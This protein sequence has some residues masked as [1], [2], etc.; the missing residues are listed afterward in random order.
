RCSP[1]TANG[2][3]RI[4]ILD[5]EL[6][7]SD[8]GHGV[9]PGITMGWRCGNIRIG[10]PFVV[11]QLIDEP[12]GLKGSRRLDLRHRCAESRAAVEMP[13]RVGV[14]FARAGGPWVERGG[15]LLA[16]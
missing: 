14:P 8:I 9:Q 6:H 10:R 2:V 11:E 1:R 13:D 5:T 4:L 7:G 16:V 12:T 3:V 15:D